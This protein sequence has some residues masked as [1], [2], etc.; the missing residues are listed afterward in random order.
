MTS[1]LVHASYAGFHLLTALAL[2]SPYMNLTRYL[3]LS[4]IDSLF[5]V[6]CSFM[7]LRRPVG[8]THLCCAVL[9]V[10]SI[11]IFFAVTHKP[12]STSRFLGTVS[13]ETP[14]WTEMK[15]IFY[16]CAAR[17]CYV[18]RGTLSKVLGSGVVEVECSR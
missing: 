15:A 6:L 5:T 9:S 1:L 8:T 7:F 17:L 2:F 14:D 18:L 10:V 3:V 13:L 16:A 4:Q 11:A 12:S